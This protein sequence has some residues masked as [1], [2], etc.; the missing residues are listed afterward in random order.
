M[1]WEEAGLSNCI[2]TDF[3]VKLS[4]LPHPPSHPHPLPPSHQ[5]VLLTSGQIKEEGEGEEEQ[6]F[7]NINV[8]NLCS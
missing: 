7:K 8:T 3:P 2:L 5:T 1:G 6:F 4:F